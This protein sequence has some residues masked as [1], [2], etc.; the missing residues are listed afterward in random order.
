[1]PSF[2][3]AVSDVD[4]RYTPDRS[5]PSWLGDYEALAVLPSDDIATVWTDNREGPSHVYFA[6][7]LP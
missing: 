7:G 4:L 3:A 6:R 2:G 5:W 1:M